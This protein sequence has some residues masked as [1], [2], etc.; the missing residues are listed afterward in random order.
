MCL[1]YGERSCTGGEGAT[2]REV[3]KHSS[4]NKVVMVDIDEVVT[5]FCKEHLTANTAAFD[6]PRL[7]LIHDDARAQLEQ[8]PGKFDVIIGDLAD[9]VEG[10]PCY[11]VNSVVPGPSP[12]PCLWLSIQYNKYILTVRTSPLNDSNSSS[13]PANGDSVSNKDLQLPF[14][15]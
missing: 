5:K 10:G 13:T 12:S 8:Y 11:Q 4:V 6:D 15:A 2:A 7:Q 9:P 1:T 14:A 3:L